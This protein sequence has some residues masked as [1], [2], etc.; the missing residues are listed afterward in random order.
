MSSLSETKERSRRRDVRLGFFLMKEKRTPRGPRVED[1]VAVDVVGEEQRAS[2][3]AIKK[4]GLSPYF[5]SLDRLGES[6]VTS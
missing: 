4:V 2:H 6:P 1:S 3:A 5:S